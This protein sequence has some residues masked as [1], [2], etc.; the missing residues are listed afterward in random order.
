MKPKSNAKPLPKPLYCEGER[1]WRPGRPC[2]KHA[3]PLGRE[4]EGTGFG[5]PCPECWPGYDV[6][7]PVKPLVWPDVPA[8]YVVR[9]APVL[10]S[11]PLDTKRFAK[12]L[13]HVR[14]NGVLLD[15]IVWVEAQ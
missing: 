10:T 11:P 12:K 3:A 9:D 6:I 14:M 8:F 5:L 13:I 2:D 7:V 4:P 15:A 1:Y